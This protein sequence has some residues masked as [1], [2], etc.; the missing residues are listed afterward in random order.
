LNGDFG[1]DFITS[2][3]AIATNFHEGSEVKPKID[4]IVA[5]FLNVAMTVA[6]LR[7]FNS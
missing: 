3:R 6:R 4:F 1:D 7:A 5:R 2:L